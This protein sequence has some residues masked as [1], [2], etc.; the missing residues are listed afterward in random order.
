MVY[1]SGLLRLVATIP[2]P[3][4]GRMDY[5][6]YDLRKQ[7][8]FISGESNKELVVV[9]LKAGKVIHETKLDG[10]PRKPFFEPATNELWVNL[11]NN[12]VVAISGTT[13][14]VTK[15]VEMTG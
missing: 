11:G 1:M 12:T 13:Y 6:A 14:E 5:C 9:D 15:T 8:L 3:T 4:E 2:L 10:S 7:H